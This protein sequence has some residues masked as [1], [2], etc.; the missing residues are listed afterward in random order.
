MGKYSHAGPGRALDRTSPPTP[1]QQPQSTSVQS[2][3]HRILVVEDSPVVRLY[4]KHTL[5]ALQPPVTVAEAANGLEGLQ[6]LEKGA[7]DLVFCDLDMPLLDGRD[8][9]SIIRGHGH[10]ERI[11]IFT[12]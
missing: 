2:Q 8:L 7:F 6:A 4:L 1:A 9:C 12:S 3:A 5:E 11:V 10:Q